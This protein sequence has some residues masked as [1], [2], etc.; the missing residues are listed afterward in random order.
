MRFA[1]K[2]TQ[3]WYQIWLHCPNS[4]PIFLATIRG[5]IPRNV[6]ISQQQR[7]KKPQISLKLSS[8][9][10][11]LIFFMMDSEAWFSPPMQAQAETQRSE[12]S[13]FLCL[14]QG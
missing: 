10:S 7:L 6:W 14:P 1:A 13:F 12:F 9:G 3:K 11:T 4:Y 5:S 8:W 2:I